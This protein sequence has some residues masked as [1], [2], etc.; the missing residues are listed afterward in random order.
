MIMK[1]GQSCQMTNDP[2][3]PNPYSP[4]EQDVLVELPS[5][6]AAWTLS[7]G[8]TV[9]LGFLAPGVPLMMMKRW[10]AGLAW[11]LAIPVAFAF[12]GP[13]WGLILFQGTAYSEVGLYPFL[14]VLC[15]TPIGSVIDCLAT[16][17]R[18]RHQQ[19]QQDLERDESST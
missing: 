13:F 19:D 1:G 12:F 8:A 10:L 3:S 4:P 15:L 11:L 7:V 16:R 6:S 17:E 5:R 9:T 18:I 2:E 14:F